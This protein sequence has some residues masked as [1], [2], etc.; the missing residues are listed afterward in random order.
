LSGSQTKENIETNSENE[1]PIVG[2]FV[3]R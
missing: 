1:T 3:C 2:V